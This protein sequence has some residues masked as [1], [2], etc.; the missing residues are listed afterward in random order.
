MADFNFIRY[1]N[2]WEDANLLL[3]ALDITNKTGL[4]VLSGGDNTLA[5][6]LKNPQKIVAFDI[7]ET[8]IHLFN[9]KKAGIKY[10]C[11][12]DFV[13]LLGVYNTS[14]SYKIFQTLK[15]KMEPTS[16]QFFSEHPDYFRKGIINIGKFEHY[17]Q[18]FKRFIIP[19]FATKKQIQKL[20]SFQDVA[21]Q[22]AYY[23]TVIN[24]RRLNAIFNIFF[25]FKVMGK[26]GRDKS[27]Y[28]HV[29]SK[30]NSGQKFREHFDYGITHIA[31][32][33]NPYI[34][35]ILTN[36]FSEHCLPLYLQKQNFDIIK[37]RIDRVE[38]KN[39]D[40]IGITGKYDF[41]N[42]SDIFE[43]LDDQAYKENCVKLRA[44]SKPNSQIAYYNMQGKRY[45]DSIH[46]ELQE[47]LSK[48][49]TEK[50][51]AYFYN[52]FLLYKVKIK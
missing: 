15:D 24:N 52:E 11:Y 19:T 31:N 28:D 32:Y 2:C 47:K 23:E 50:M 29:E 4:S 48:D 38:I 3:D 22:K 8:Q 13:S 40:L 37:Q 44:I 49:C 5:M 43:Y 35:Y 17:F 20:A 9:L 26:F 45:L 42:L 33:N 16:F 10:L 25:G 21:K 6:L 30:K 51:Q 46:F 41:F 18:L 14:K 1:A 34:N 7:N 36:H 12:D 39:T 27:F